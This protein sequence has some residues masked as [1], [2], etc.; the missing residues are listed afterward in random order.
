[1]KTKARPD[2]KRIRGLKLVRQDTQLVYWW[3]GTKD[4][5]VK[6]VQSASK[7]ELTIEFFQAGIQWDVVG[8]TEAQVRRE[9]AKGL[10]SLKPLVAAL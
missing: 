2:I 9:F 3:Y 1:M 6:L 4:I 5:N 8:R 7:W 10:R